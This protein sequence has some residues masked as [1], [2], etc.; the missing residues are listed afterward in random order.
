MI[1]DKENELSDAQVVTVTAVSTNVIDLVAPANDLGVGENLYLIVAVETLL[2]AAG[3]AV[4]TVTLEGDDNEAFTSAT[5]LK[6]LGTFDATDVAGT[7]LIERISPELLTEQFYRLR[8]TVATGPLTTGS[9]FDA[10]I[11]HGLQ[12]EKSYADNVTIS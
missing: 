5:V 10:F 7:R 2:T 4:V 8:Y 12:A 3:A 11:V 9:A 6:T 1:M